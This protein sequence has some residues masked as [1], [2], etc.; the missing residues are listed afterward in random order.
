MKILL[1]AALIFTASPQDAP[2]VARYDERGRMVKIFNLASEETRIRCAR[3]LKSGAVIGVE[4]DNERRI[5]NFTL[6]PP[7]G[8]A[9]KFYL[10]EREAITEADAARLSSL[11]RRGVRLR[12]TSYGCGASGG[13]QEPD[14]IERV[15]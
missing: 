14:V 11:I 6:K 15:P 1:L 2:P 3:F 5:V 8:R 7:R 12:V 13:F 4:H 10:A 9:E